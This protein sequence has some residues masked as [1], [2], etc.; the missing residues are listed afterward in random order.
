TYNI[1]DALN[2]IEQDVN[3]SGAFLSTNNFDPSTPQGYNDDTAK[4]KNVSADGTALILNVYATTGNPISSN[5]DVIYTADQP[6]ACSDGNISSNPPVM[7]NVVYFVKD[8]SLYRRV[9]APSFYATVGC[10]VPWQ[11]PSCS[12]GYVDSFCKSTDVRL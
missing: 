1:Q 11:T 9:V 12:E 5:S 6:K 2:R 8:N 7:M 10:S 4:F 3:S